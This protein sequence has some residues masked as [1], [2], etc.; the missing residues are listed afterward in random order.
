MTTFIGTAAGY[1][2][3]I[4]KIDQHLTATGHAWGLTFAGTG[5]GR[6]RGPGGTVGGYIGTAT[7]VTETVTVT[8]TSATAF[9][10]VGSVSGSMGSG[11]VGTDFVHSRLTFRVV[12]GG[13]PFASGDVFTMNTGPAWTRQRLSG[14]GNTGDGFTS[15]LANFPNLIDGSA[16]TSATTTTFPATT[17][18]VMDFDTM[19]RSI[20]IQNAGTAGRGPAAFSLEWSNDGLSWTSLQSWSGVGSWLANEARIFTVTAPIARRRWRI[21][22][23]AAQT[24]T[25]ELWELR[26]C[27]DAAATRE[28]DNNNSGIQAIWQS[29]GVDGVTTAFH[30]FWTTV[31]PASDV[32]NLRLTGFRFWNDQAQQPSL[33]NIANQSTAKTMPLTK[34]T[35]MAY[36]L[37]VNGAR[38]ILVVRISGVY[39]AAYSGFILPYEVPADYPWPMAVGAVYDV[40]TARW[41]LSNQGGFR[42]FWD[43]GASTDG[44]NALCSLAVAQPNGVWR[45]FA[46]RQNSSG[47]E[48]TA[49]N[50]TNDR[51]GL[52]WPYGVG[53]DSGVQQVS[54]FRDCLDGSLPLLP[55][56]IAV[57]PLP[58]FTGAVLGEFDGV[59]AMNGFGNTT[60]ALTRDGAIDVLSVTNVFRT[61]RQ[62][63]AGIALD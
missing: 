62:N 48:G 33:P 58:D 1:R 20:R 46:N 35:S 47:A 18:W 44:A 26:L 7:S 3:L 57:P 45:E 60:E 55:V 32:W 27:E 16:S 49:A 19:V 5:N 12:A 38:Y 24:A 2:D 36:W 13:T 8:F 23:T 63:W 28:L 30:G 56:L 31:V 52:T 14:M 9:N 54:V 50:H 39:L 10:V 17:T 4:G 40:A 34:T 22:V 43:P 6:L 42:N 61:T 21:V 37:V 59:Y 11:T 25:L 41:D 15:T 29:P 51:W 53:R